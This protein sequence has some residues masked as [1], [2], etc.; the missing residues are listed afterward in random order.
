MARSKLHDDLSARALRWVAAR[1]TRA[2][3][4]ASTEVYL[5]REYVADAAAVG[6]LQSRFRR[7]LGC[8]ADYCPAASHWLMIFEVKVARADFLSTF[9]DARPA[10]GDRAMPVGSCHW[11]VRAKGV[12]TCEL[13][14]F[15]GVLEQS[16]TGLR[17]VRRPLV[18][19][20]APETL[21]RAGYAILWAASSDRRHWKT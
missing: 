21:H 9:G 17:E 13:P 15:W 4:R 7:A 8:P 12:K 20:I 19:D 2:G 14:T 10:Y 18:Y 6:M 1:A 3:I 16:S 11:C 5:D